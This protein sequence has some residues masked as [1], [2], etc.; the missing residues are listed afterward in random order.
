[1]PTD[2]YLIKEIN[3]NVI[4]TEQNATGEITFYFRGKL[5]TMPCSITVDGNKI[6]IIS[7]S[8]TWKLNNYKADGTEFIF[9]DA[10]LKYFSKPLL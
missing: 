3:T 6:Q 9:G 4:M 1:M 10:E 5:E 2:D 8:H 7:D